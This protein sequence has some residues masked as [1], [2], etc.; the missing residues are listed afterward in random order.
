MSPNCGLSFEYGPPGTPESVELTLEADSSSDGADSVL[1]AHH[2]CTL[3]IKEDI[4]RSLAPAYELMCT[5][6]TPGTSSSETTT[7]A[8]QSAAPAG[9][10]QPVTT[11]IPID[12]AELLLGQTKVQHEWPSEQHTMPKALAAVLS[13]FTLTVT[14]RV[15]RPEDSD[16]PVGELE[17]TP[18]LPPGL[19]EQLSPLVM[20]L[21]RAVS[22]PD[23]P[24]TTAQ[25][26]TD[27]YRCCFLLWRT[28]DICT[29]G[30][31]SGHQLLCL[32]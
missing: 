4:V 32:E 17:V 24:A 29:I 9:G 13:Q 11:Q 6:T 27:C 25:L 21:Y 18:F 8:S 7:D 2:F 26:D 12:I 5:V 14:T 16:S 1:Q 19:C 31:I 15:H 30:I 23:K 3:V 22:L 20:H 10:S 28:P